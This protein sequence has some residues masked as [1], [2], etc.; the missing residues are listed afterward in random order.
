MQPATASIARAHPP[1]PPRWR[2]DRLAVL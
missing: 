2:V 1:L